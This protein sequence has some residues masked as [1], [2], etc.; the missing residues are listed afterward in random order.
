MYTYRCHGLFVFR[1]V[2]IHMS[3]SVYVFSD[4]VYS[5]P[6]KPDAMQFMNLLESFDLKQHVDLPTYIDGHSHI[7]S[8]CSPLYH[9]TQQTGPSSKN[10]QVPILKI[11]QHEGFYVTSSSLLSSTTDSVS[12]LVDSY[13]TILTNIADKHAPYK[14]K[15]NIEHP[16]AV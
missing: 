13:I 9:L 4:I 6:N 2:Y 12:E 11:Y 5:Y 1:H 7:R 10:L 14:L 3:Q 15:T 8:F 16:L